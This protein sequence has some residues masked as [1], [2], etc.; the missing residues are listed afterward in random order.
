MKTLNPIN[1]V[2][3]WRLRKELA[4]YASWKLGQKLAGRDRQHASPGMDP[5][6]AEHVEFALELFGS[7]AGGDRAARWGSTSS[8]WPTA[9]A[10]W[11]SCRS[12]CRTRS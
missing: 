2:H 6:L 3:A 4:P 5:R 8:S 1:P 7:C 12:A 9:S 11:P 10:A